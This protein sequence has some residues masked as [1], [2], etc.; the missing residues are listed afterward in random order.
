MEIIK[1]IFDLNKAI[2]NLKDCGF[3]PT[4]GG[5]HE[6]H[7]NLIKKSQKKCSKTIVSIFV[8]P[9]QFNNKN[10]FYKYPRDLKRDIKILKKLNVDIL[11]VPEKREIYNKKFKKI[12]LKNYEKVLCAKFRKGHFEG[13]L[14]IMNR[15]IYFVR[16]RNIFMGEKDFQQFFLVKKYLAKK[17]Q[18]KIIRCKT[19]RDKNGIALSTRN[20]LLSKNSYTKIVAIVN[21]L[22]KLKRKL[23]LGK[24]F[25]NVNLQ[26]EITRFENFYKI[27][28]DYLE[29]KNFQDLNKSPTKTNFRLF[30][31]FWIN[32]VRLIDNY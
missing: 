29:I 8:N 9:T 3:V 18:V 7:I 23:K 19:V 22:K 2:N 11:F 30:V 1:K 31:A 5:I 4:M 10:D 14:N 6:G 26:N 21:E 16:A 24:Y 20:N 32:N 25:Y 15:L 17:F 27:K 12:K 13:V 28:I